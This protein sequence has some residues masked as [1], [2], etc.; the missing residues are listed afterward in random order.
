[1]LRVGVVAVPQPCGER[2]GVEPLGGVP[3]GPLL[4]RSVL[5]DGLDAEVRFGEKRVGTGTLHAEEGC[6]PNPTDQSTQ[7]RVRTLPPQR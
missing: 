7:G 2:R 1:V 6:Q 5:P 4:V 3:G